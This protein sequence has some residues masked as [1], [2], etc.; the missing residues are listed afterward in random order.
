LKRKKKGTPDEWAFKTLN[1]IMTQ[2]HKELL[3]KHLI[4]VGYKLVKDKSGKTIDDVIT[5]M[6]N[7]FIQLKKLKQHYD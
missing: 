2:E 6:K 4:E 5:D 1:N 3:G 7:V